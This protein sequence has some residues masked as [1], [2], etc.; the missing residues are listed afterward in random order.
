MINHV[1]QLVSPKLFSIKYVDEDIC[2]SVVIKPEYMSVCHADQRYYMGARTREVLE[3]KLPMALIHE[4]CGRVVSDMTGQFNVGELVTVVPNTPTIEDTQI[5]ENYRSGS[6]FLSSGYDGFMREYVIAKPE[7]V[8]RLGDIPEK[9]GAIT[10]FLSV[11]AHAIKRLGE[12]AHRERN[13]IGIWGDGSLAY[14]V[15]NLLRLEYQQAKITVIGRN[16]NKLNYFSFVDKT[17]VAGAIPKDFAVDHAIEC[18][19]GEGSYFALKDIIEFIKPQGTT[20]LMGVTENEVAVNTRMLLEKGITMVGCSRSGK[21]D[22]I[23]ATEFLNNKKVQNRIS[24][25]IYEDTPVRNVEDIHRVFRTDANTPFKTV[26]RW[27]L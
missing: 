19:G 15:A 5:Y 13:S 24:Q 12:T 26:F 10:E 14:V 6:Y 16:I 7:R 21:E 3:K 18:C 17:Y 20:V 27:K 1:Y 8:V 11:A 2:N 9:V 23:K 4:F 25:I 22:F